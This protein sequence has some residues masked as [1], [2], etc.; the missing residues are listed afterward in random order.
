MFERYTPSARRAIFYA[1]AITLLSERAEITS[2]DLLGGLLFS[3]ESR[4]QTIF[5]L[6]ERFPVYSG[7]PY[8][9]S[10]LPEVPTGPPLANDSKHALAE[11]AW[12]A[13]RLGDYWID[14]EHLLLGIMRARSC[15]AS[16]YLARTGLTLNAARKAIKDS[17]PSRPDYGPVPLQWRIKLRLFRLM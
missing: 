3:E 17:K 4:V 8:K 9:H 6:R 11:A 13:T 1:R 15:V 2:V 16:A 12:E 7:C 10:T 5:Q 14:N